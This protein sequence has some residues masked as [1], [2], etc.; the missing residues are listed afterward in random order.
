MLS[1]KKSLTIFVLLSVVLLAFV[2]TEVL[3]AETPV[4]FPDSNLEQAIRDAIDKPTG[5][6]YESD[7]TTLTYLDAED[8]DIVDLTGLEYCAA[9]TSLELDDN[10]IVDISPV[11]GLTN[12][13]VVNLNKNQIVDI[14]PV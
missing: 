4:N 10:Q 3:G 2:E 13:T 9:L 7:L 1:K 8:R 11:S 6:I 5:D 12:L 14:S